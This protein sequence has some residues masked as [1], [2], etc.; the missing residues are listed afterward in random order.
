MFA[1][2]HMCRLCTLQ[3]IISRHESQDANFTNRFYINCNTHCMSLYNGHGIL[4]SEWVLRAESVKF[5]EDR[6]WHELFSLC[7][8]RLLQRVYIFTRR[9]S[10]RQSRFM[11]VA[12]SKLFGKS[13]TSI[14][15]RLTRII[16]LFTVRFD[17]WHRYEVLSIVIAVS[18]FLHAM[19]CRDII[20][21]HRARSSEGGNI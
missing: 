11:A 19:I 7:A 5:N 18:L 4:M 2:I 1:L 15:G 8:R 14:H 12:L 6:D 9:I 3:A 13:D 10:C 16:Y 20:N 17:E 21:D